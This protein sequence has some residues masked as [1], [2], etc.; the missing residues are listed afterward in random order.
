MRREYPLDASR[1]LRAF[2]NH[3]KRLV[4]D[5][6]AGCNADTEARVAH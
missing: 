2:T 6:R 3:A 5:D 1:Y 4:S